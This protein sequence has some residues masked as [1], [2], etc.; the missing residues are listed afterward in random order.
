[1]AKLIISICRTPPHMFALEHKPPLP[2]IVGVFAENLWLWNYVSHLFPDIS[3]SNNH[4]S[5]LQ[6]EIWWWESIFSAFKDSIISSL[7]SVCIWNCVKDI[8][9]L[10]NRIVHK[11]V[12]ILCPRKLFKKL[13]QKSAISFWLY[14]AKWV[15]EYHQAIRRINSL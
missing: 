11:P 7:S 9:P 12:I 4:K 2:H 1:M 8:F 15:A 5:S 14:T 10:D 3:T 6:I 13:P